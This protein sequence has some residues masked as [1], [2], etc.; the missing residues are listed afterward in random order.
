MFELMSG[1]KIMFTK[2]EI[3][4]INVDNEV[5]QFYS[6][7]FCCQVG[8][9]DPYE[10]SWYASNFYNLKN[11][12]WDFLDAK[13]LKKLDS[14]IGDSATRGGR[15]VLLDSSLSSIPY[16]YMSMF[17]LKKTFLEKLDKHRRSFFWAGKTKKRKYYMVKWTR[18]CRSK[19]KGGLGVKDLRK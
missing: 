19:K 7:L 14:W 3:F 10:I 5:T 6:D 12:D 4:T 9:L 1:L 2:S 18:I 11:V 16:F 8:Q 13:V 17:L 15:L